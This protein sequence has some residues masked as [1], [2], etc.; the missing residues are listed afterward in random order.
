MT[1]TGSFADPSAEDIDLGLNLIDPRAVAVATGV[2]SQPLFGAGFGLRSG[3]PW[4]Q[5]RE[6][7][8]AAQLREQL[9]SV[10]SVPIEW[11]AETA[12]TI[13]W[14]WSVDQAGCGYMTD[15]SSLA[16]TLSFD[17]RW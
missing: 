11:E 12:A 15:S 1:D 3:G 16:R 4:K 5:V 2:E 7:D 14:G 13:C 10:Y 17:E 9:G 8:S 6:H